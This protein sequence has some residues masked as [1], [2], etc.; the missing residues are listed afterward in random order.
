MTAPI[1][2]GEIS[3]AEVGWLIDHQ[4]DIDPNPPFQRGS[5]VWDRSMKQKLID[6]VLNGY[7]IPKFYLAD[8]ISYQEA[9]SAGQ[10]AIIDGKQRYAALVGFLNDEFPLA[11]D[12]V[13]APDPTVDVSGYTYS[14]ITMVYPEIATRFLRFP[15]AIM[16]VRTAEERHINQLF[17]RLNASKALFSA[18]KRSAME[19]PVVKLIGL[20]AEH[21]F[22]GDCIGFKTNRGENKNLAAKILMFEYDGEMSAANKSRLDRFVARANPTATEEQADEAQSFEGSM[23][24]LTN[25]VGISNG[26]LDAAYARAVLVLDR[27]RAGLQGEHWTINSAGNAPVFYWLFR[28]NPSYDPARLAGFL[29]T[30]SDGV[31]KAARSIGSIVPGVD[32]ITEDEKE[33]ALYYSYQR[34]GN[35]KASLQGRYLLLQRAFDAF[36]ATAAV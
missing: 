32:T 7:D 25:D 30:Y 4:R 27:M 9:S 3:G 24:D 10:Y 26:T 20:L 36:V 12:F 19:G 6:T 17:L 8:T 23:E 14:Q 13:F 15:L 28:E 21:S 1:S 5:N 16:L 33:Y 2:V 11:T 18:E 35:D 34:R 31:A 22:F 29:R